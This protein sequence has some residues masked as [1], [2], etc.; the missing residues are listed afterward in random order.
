M[1]ARQRS[2]FV[3]LLAWI[4][5]I[6]SGFGTMIFILQNIMVHIMFDMPEF[7]EA[8]QT[9]MPGAPPFMA[10]LMAHFRWFAGL[11]LLSTIVTLVASIGLLKRKNWARLTIVTML[12]LS[13][14][15]NLAGM[16]MQLM[17]LPAMQAQFPAIPDAPDMR[18]FMIAIAIFSLLITLAFTV[19]FGWIVKRLLSPAIVAEFQ[20]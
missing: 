3:T 8:L 16:V 2:T 11:L 4:F 1:N 20:S 18:I 15:S 12:I 19:L 7:Q 6:L 13:I 9:P 5:I 17:A 10:F 14:F